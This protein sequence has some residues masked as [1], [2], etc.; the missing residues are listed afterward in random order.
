MVTGDS[1]FTRLQAQ[2]RIA[3]SL[4]PQ[5]CFPGYSYLTPEK[6]PDAELTTV[7]SYIPIEKSGSE[8]EQQNHHPYLQQDPAKLLLTDCTT[9][10]TTDHSDHS[11]PHTEKG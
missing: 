9:T 5:T 2:Q 4:V 10:G 3:D 1:G 7:S 11:S 8:Q 6:I